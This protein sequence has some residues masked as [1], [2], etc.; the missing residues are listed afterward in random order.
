VTR[1]DENL[2]S[3][4]T[5]P[6]RE[7]YPS[8]NFSN[9]VAAVRELKHPTQIGPYHIVGLI[10][11]GGMGTV[12]KAEQ[13]Q[14]I[15]RVVAV[16]IIKLGMDTRQVVARFQSERQALALMNHPNV[17]KVLDAGATEAGRPYFVME[18]VGGE[19]ITTFADR[20]KLTVHERLELFTQACDAIQHAHQKAIIHRDLKPSNMLVTLLDDK[21]TVKV[22]DFGVAKAISHRLTER[23]LF[24]ETGQFVGTPEYMSPEQADAGPHDIDTRTDVY[25]LGVVLYELLSGALPFDA[26]SLRSGGYNEIQR[27]IRDVDPPRPSTRLSALGRGAQEVASCRRVSVESLSRQLQ[28]EL[29]WIPLKAMQKDR[30]HRYSTASEL[31]DDVQNYLNNR[32]LRAGPESA[33]YRVR[34][35]LRRNK[36][37][38][39]G[40]T[41]MIVLL[42]CGIVATTWQAVRATRAE[43][44]A[45]A[46]SENLKEV[47][48]FLT[49]DLLASASPEVT[50]GRDLTV[51]EAVD[52]AARSVAERFEKRPLT[53]AAVRAVLA[54]T[55]DSL[56]LTETSLQHARAAMEIYARLGGPNDP[57]ALL[58]AERVGRAL[59]TLNRHDEAEPLLRDTYERAQTVLGPDH[60]MTIECASGLAMTLR[61]QRRFAEAEPLYRRVLK[62]D[63][64]RYGNQSDEAARAMNNLAVLLNTQGRA[65]EAGPLYLQ[66]LE[67]RERLYG[68]D[69]PSYLSSLS[70]YAR[71]LETQGKLAEGIAIQREVLELKRRV[72]KDDHPSTTLTMNNL[73][74]LLTQGGKYAEAEALHREALERRLRTLGE[75]DIDTVQ[76]MHNLGRALTLQGK[77]AEGEKLHRKALDKRRRVL[78][79]KHVDTISAA[80]GLAYVYEQQ[81]RWAEAEPLL[82]SACETGAISQLPANHAATTMARLGFCL[83]KEG[84]LPA[85]EP[86]LV[87]AWNR[88]SA[89]GQGRSD[90]AQRTLS[91]LAEMCR[92]TGRP[93]Q[94]QK[95]Q[96]QLSA[97]GSP[98]ATMP[99]K[100]P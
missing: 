48:Q 20:H 32:P 8:E 78:G 56:G 92:K 45:R 93:D 24:T 76:S 11:E 47:N 35:F 15:H 82:A 18:Y 73:G 67:I 31:S 89:T 16:K 75:D 36:R 61:M 46:V 6:S 99:A 91:L 28:T 34:K 88:L 13:R 90:A 96:A 69:H 26:K 38:V 51:R 54:D 94:A 84:K 19:P 37:A 27:I 71:V 64:L 7:P 50:R 65:D 14:P 79:E 3:T 59:A 41:T 44:S 68:R 77:Y 87:D 81:E 12:Y 57:Q 58:S 1:S 9:V 21:P 72:L 52:R 66:A 98:P 74:A 29:D 86:I 83:A 60:G 40:A 42:L 80:M 39:M 10:G 49:Q 33:K 62:S 55:Y 25:S 17:A 23:T 5:G 85:A 43:A 4:P 95:W 2:D 30:S 97:L 100:S 22:I 70:N 53:E 63:S